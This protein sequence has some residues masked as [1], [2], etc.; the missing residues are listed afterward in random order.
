MFGIRLSLNIAGILAR[1]S[2]GGCSGRFQSKRRIFRSPGDHSRGIYWLQKGLPRFQCP[3]LRY[4]LFA[5]F[6]SLARP[7]CASFLS[8][9]HLDTVSTSCPNSLNDT[10]VLRSIRDC[11]YPLS[12]QLILIPTQPIANP[13]ALIPENVATVSARIPTSSNMQWFNRDIDLRSA[14]TSPNL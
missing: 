10:C 12:A 8:L 1:V 9:S 11:S 6:F 3:K 4:Y 14:G 13:E 7:K 5:Q 2:L